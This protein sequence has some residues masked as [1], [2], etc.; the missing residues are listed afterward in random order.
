MSFETFLI[1]MLILAVI[2]IL[3]VDL[4]HRIRYTKLQKSFEVAQLRIKLHER[5]SATD[6]PTPPSMRNGTIHGPL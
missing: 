4:V 6:K 5:V 2:A 3:A 1:C